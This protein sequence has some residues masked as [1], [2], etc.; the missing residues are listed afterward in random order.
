MQDGGKEKGVHCEDMFINHYEAQVKLQVQFEHFIT[1]SYRERC[2]EHPV[3][4][5][6]LTKLPY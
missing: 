5:M 6:S 2:L 4:L 3:P 1:C